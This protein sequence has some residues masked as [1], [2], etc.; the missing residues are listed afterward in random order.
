MN[1]FCLTVRCFSE[2]ET[3]ELAKKVSF[4]LKSGDIVALDGE[5]GSG[6]TFFTRSIIQHSIHKAQEVSVPS[7]TFTMIQSYSGLVPFG[8]LI[9]ADLYRL[10]NPKELEELGLLEGDYKGVVMIEWSK[11]GIGYLPHFNLIISIE[12]GEKERERIFHIEGSKSRIEK[13]SF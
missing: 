6:K 10:S 9:H 5:I 8:N 12:Y 11:N 4:L 3:I 2:Y 1:Q 7:P 13:I